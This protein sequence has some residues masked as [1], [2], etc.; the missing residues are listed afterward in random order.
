MK[1]MVTYKE[2]EKV[3]N[4][5]NENSHLLDDQLDKL[6]LLVTDMKNNWQGEAADVFYE[7]IESYVEKV[8]KVPVCH[9]NISSII[10]FLNKNY[11]AIDKEYAQTLKNAVVEHE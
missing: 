2:L 9:R 8:R 4:N 10:N 11:N 7:S 3:S 1:L 6:I 5:F